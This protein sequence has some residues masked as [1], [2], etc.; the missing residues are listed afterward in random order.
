MSRGG[1]AVDAAVRAFN[2]GMTALLSAPAAGK[3]LRRG[4]TTITYTGR[5]SGRT[6]S[7][8][9]SF[10]RQGDTVRI[11]V[12]AAGAKNWWRNFQEGGHPA[13]LRLDGVDRAGH[14]VATRDDAGR[15]WVTITL[16]PTP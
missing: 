16:D 12:M 2:A 13:V 15:L 14:G 6:F 9:V 7:T 10:R 1:S 4:M 5:R 8:P 3:L 11:L